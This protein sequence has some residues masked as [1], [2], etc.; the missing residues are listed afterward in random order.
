MGG[1]RNL[2]GLLTVAVLVFACGPNLRGPQPATGQ[3]LYEAI[4]QSILVIDSN[5]HSVERRLPLGTPS[6]DWT[7]LYS[8]LGDSLL[9]TDPLTGVT[10][11]TVRVGPGYLLPPATSTGLPGGLSPAGHWLV[12][13]A[14]DASATHMTV[15]DTASFK[16]T[17]RF[18]LSGRFNFDAISDDGQ[19]L[20][21]IQYLNGK[22][23]YVRLFDVPGNYLDANIVVDKSDGNQ[24]MAGVR[25]SGI[26]APDGSMLFS[27]YVRE[28]ES[29]FIHALNLTGPFAFCLDLPGNGYTQDRAAMRWSLAMSRDGSRLYA[30]NGATGVVAELDSSNQFSPQIL[31]TTHLN[32]GSATTSGADTAVLSLDGKTLITAS[33]AGIVLVDTKSLLVRV[34]ALTEWRVSSLGLSPDGKTLFVVSETGQVAEVSMASGAAI[35]RFDPGVGNPTALMR[36][37]AS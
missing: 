34:Q 14:S 28:S 30:I 6:S 7:H 20:Y 2:F 31:R 32:T 4:G 3:K 36:V 10:Q 23:Y 25:L 22:E 8:M 29:P 15:V 5:N 16:V 35:A 17:D 24:A 11:N 12:L 21:L 33:N 13:Q 27:M 37:S 1:M 18:D 19:R 26:A 9:D